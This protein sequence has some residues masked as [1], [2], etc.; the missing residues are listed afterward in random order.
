MIGFR[1]AVINAKFG[2]CLGQ[3][4][5]DVFRF[6]PTFDITT[7]VMKI[8]IFCELSS[9][10][11]SSKSPRNTQ[12]HVPWARRLDR[13]SQFQ[14]NPLAFQVDAWLIDLYNPI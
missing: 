7:W 12:K 2:Q 3:M 14:T 6:S 9:Q 8:I 11:S 10:K 1:N 4:F 13:P 5:S